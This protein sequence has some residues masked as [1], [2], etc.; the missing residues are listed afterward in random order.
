MTFFPSPIFTKERPRETTRSDCRSISVGHPLFDCERACLP[1]S[2]TSSSTQYV[3]SGRAEK[4]PPTSSL[5]SDDFGP[6]C[7]PHMDAV[8]DQ[9]GLG[10]GHAVHQDRPSARGRSHHD[11]TVPLHQIQRFKLSWIEKGEFMVTG[12]LDILPWGHTRDGSRWEV[13]PRQSRCPC[14]SW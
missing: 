13:V 3:F 9:E 10:F 1:I 2:S 14:R 5:N 8:R 12:S 7:L 4:P 11:E 6:A